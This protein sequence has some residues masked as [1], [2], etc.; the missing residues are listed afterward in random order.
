MA[1]LYVVH[2]IFDGIFVGVFDGINSMLDHRLG[3]GHPDGSAM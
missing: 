2:G 3:G 1:A